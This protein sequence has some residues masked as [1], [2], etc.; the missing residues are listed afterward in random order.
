[1]VRGEK[2]ISLNGFLKKFKANSQL[3]NENFLKT[4]ANEAGLQQNQI[5]Q[6][7]SKIVKEKQS[8]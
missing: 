3:F 5:F 4:D 7:G 6:T 8:N 2:S 1:M